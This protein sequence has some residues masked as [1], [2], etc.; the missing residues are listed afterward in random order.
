VLVLLPQGDTA[1]REAVTQR[2]GAGTAMVGTP[3]R[4]AGGGTDAN[5]AAAAAAGPWPIDRGTA[6]RGADVVEAGE[7]ASPTIHRSTGACDALIA[8][9]SRR[10]R[11]S[12][13]R[14]LQLGLGPPFVV[15]ILVQSRHLSDISHC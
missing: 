11:A 13:V 9:A 1:C 4:T 8:G 14:P 3:A 10:D 5:T 6:A 15:A 7:P 12:S 2:G